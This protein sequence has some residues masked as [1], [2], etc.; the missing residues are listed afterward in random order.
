MNYLLDTHTFLWWVSNSRQLSDTS[1]DIIS[2][3]Y[4]RIFISIASQWE[5]GIKASIGRLD[6]P[7]DELSVSIEK[8]GFESLAINADHITESAHL[9]MHHRDPFDRMLI[10]QARLESLTLI[11]K[12]T[13]FPNYDLAL[14]W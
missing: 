1:R 7:I 9:P 13:T 2:D 6:F 14:V 11:S 8:N 5:I 3:G 10:A 4:N 12:D